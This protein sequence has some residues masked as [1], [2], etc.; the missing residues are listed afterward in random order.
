MKTELMN[1]IEEKEYK[2]ELEIIDKKIEDTYKQIYVYSNPKLIMHLR[3]RTLWHK[4]C[5]KFL[6]DILLQLCLSAKQKNQGYGI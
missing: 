6:G 2:I 1:K 3:M 4:L 5:H